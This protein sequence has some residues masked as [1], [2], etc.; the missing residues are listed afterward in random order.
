MA[1]KER[2]IAYAVVHENV[3]V[4]DCIIP[5]NLDPFQTSVIFAQP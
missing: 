5:S 1:P 2:I 4:S 3:E